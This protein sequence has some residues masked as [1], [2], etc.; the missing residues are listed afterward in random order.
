MKLFICATFVLLLAAL[1]VYFLGTPFVASV[2]GISPRTISVSAGLAV[3]LLGLAGITV[4][5][6]AAQRGQRE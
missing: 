5:K 3:I 1:Y 4:G 2:T 6:R